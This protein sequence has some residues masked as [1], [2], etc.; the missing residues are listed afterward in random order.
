MTSGSVSSSNGSGNSS[1][2]IPSPSQSLCERLLRLDRALNLAVSQ[3]RYADAASLHRALAA[4]RDGDPWLSTRAALADAVLREDFVAAAKLRDEV[5]QLTK[6]LSVEPRVDGEPHRVDR[7]VVLRGRP[8]QPG[9]LR[10]ATVS[11]DGSIDMPLE[12]PH[13]PTEPC[14]TDQ[15]RIYLQPCFSPSGDFV[16]CTEIT[17]R[18]LGSEG[19]AKVVSM[20]ETTHR[21]VVLN[22]FDGSI[23][24]SFPVRKPPFFF[25]WTA[26]GTKLTMLYNGTPA[27]PAPSSSSSSSLLT[28]SI[29]SSVNSTSPP[30]VSMSVV[31]VVASAGDKRDYPSDAASGPIVSGHPL[32]FENS[33]RDSDMFVAHL[34]DRSEVI[35]GSLS[36]SFPRTVLTYYAGSFGT[37]QWHPLSGED[38]R[39]VVLF[40]ESEVK[41]E[42]VENKASALS[43]L[44]GRAQPRVLRADGLTNKATPVGGLRQ[45]SNSDESDV[46]PVDAEYATNSGSDAGGKKRDFWNTMAI[47]FPPVDPSSVGKIIEDFVKLGVKKAAEATGVSLPGLNEINAEDVDANSAFDDDDDD[48]DDQR[49]KAKVAEAAKELAKYDSD[50]SSR[51]SDSGTASDGKS[52]RLSKLKWDKKAA[53]TG[54]LY[55]CDVKNPE[56]RKCLFECQGVSSFKLS[57]DASTLALLVKIAETGDDELSLRY[58]DFTP[59]SV[60]TGSHPDIPTVQRTYEPDV[61]LSTPSAK[62]LAFFWSP[63]SKKLLY[64]SALRK[65]AAGAA[66]WA[67]FDCESKRIARYEPFIPSPMFGH[68][69]TF[70]CS[71]RG[72]STPWSPDSDAF[73]Y[74]GRDLTEE[75]K[76]ACLDID[77]DSQ[78]NSATLLTAFSLSKKRMADSSKG[79]PFCACVQA[80]AVAEDAP[81]GKRGK[82]IVLEPRVVM[83]NVEMAAWSSR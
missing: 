6:R 36:S 42:A 30:T 43:T 67:T 45:T 46:P 28:S 76:N 72:G 35:V 41:K 80:V 49:L 10:V 71:N 57:P 58:G 14:S 5:A 52:N 61:I 22:T 25:S 54:K 29:P 27:P 60:A 40:M 50:Y 19:K 18:V 26:C 64:L 82:M 44:A 55:M 16:A 78:A 11:P 4:A 32:L 56:L 13:D 77:V 24:K 66:Q 83:A 63:D 20:A 12:P 53:T 47:K 74:A 70:F 9:R 81:E 2:A 73:C 65:N 17:F 51:S 7:I 33:P 39:E 69:L 68:G 79:A 21:V 62:V 75:E 23:V 3:E 34:G 15:P 37:P 31:H 1:S 8:D 48:D 59:D 38:G